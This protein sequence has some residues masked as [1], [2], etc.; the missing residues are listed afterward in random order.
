L[1]LVAWKRVKI[2]PK[3]KEH[4][5]IPGIG[6]WRWFILWE[7]SE[8]RVL[9]ISTVVATQVEITLERRHV[10]SNDSDIGISVDLGHSRSVARISGL[11]LG[12]VV[13]FKLERQ[14]V[15][16]VKHANHSL[17]VAHQI[18]EFAAHAIQAKCVVAICIVEQVR[19]DS[20]ANMGSLPEWFVVR[21]VCPLINHFNGAGRLVSSK[22]YTIKAQ[23]LEVALLNEFNAARIGRVT[24]TV[25]IVASAQIG[26][27]TRKASA[28]KVGDWE[29][30][31]TAVY[32]CEN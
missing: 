25:I 28:R 11:G 6:V 10:L 29:S 7:G 17:R 13:K 30:R 24:Y 4:T 15:I 32:T 8:R 19:I 5:V 16:G 21:D 26:T 27:T 1:W 9:Q 14:G 2:D 18:K 20:E 23:C 12:E 22:S 3:V 31:H